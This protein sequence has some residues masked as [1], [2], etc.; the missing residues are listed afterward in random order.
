MTNQEIMALLEK[1][2]ITTSVATTVSAEDAREF[3]DLSKEQLS[4]L[5][6][7]RVETGIVTGRK[8]D[9]IELG[10][11]VTHEDTENTDP[12]AAE[13]I[14]PTFNP[15]T[16]TPVKVRVDYDVTF[17][18]IRENIEGQNINTTLNRVFSKRHGKDVVMMAFRGDTTLADT[19]RTNK[20]LRAF[21]GFNVQ[22]A[23]S[24]DVHKVDLTGETDSTD[25]LGEV[26]PDMRDAVPTDYQDPENLVYLVSFAR[27]WHYRDQIGERATSAGDNALIGSQPITFNGIPVIPVF[28]QV[29]G[30]L[31]LTPMKNLAI[32]WGREMEVG[33]DVYNRAGRIEVTM[34]T[35]VD[36]KIAVDDA[37]VVAYAVT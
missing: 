4:I 6:K 14:A 20:A 25:L 7:L 24:S 12:A 11:P 10:E 9:N 27:Y 3:I 5:Q 35:S 32:G 33:R 15:K 21:N 18:T 16:L 22:A 23:A 8:L 19:T 13:I 1:A 37:L 2:A 36:A 29:D 28:G 31:Y 34:R 17:D 26:F 30:Y